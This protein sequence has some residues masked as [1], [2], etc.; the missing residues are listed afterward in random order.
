MLKGFFHVP[1]AVNEPVKGMHQ[2]HLKSSRSSSLKMWILKLTYLF[3][4]EA[5]KLELEIQKHGT[6]RP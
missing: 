6:T 1:K 5:K 3:I 2:I 4:S